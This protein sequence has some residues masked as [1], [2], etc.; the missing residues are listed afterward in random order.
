MP[1]CVL[2][3]DS[4]FKPC[5]GSLA[6]ALLDTKFEHPDAIGGHHT[7][8]EDALCLLIVGLAQET[9]LVFHSGRARSR[10]VSVLHE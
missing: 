10:E 1:A 5:G 6:L 3:C 8:D 7:L 4:G 2:V 9:Q